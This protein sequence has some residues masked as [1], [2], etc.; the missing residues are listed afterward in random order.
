MKKTL[1]LIM[2]GMIVFAMGTN[3]SLAAK[4]AKSAGGVSQEEMTNMSDTIDRLTKKVYSNSLFAPQ[5][6]SA[7][8]EIKIK[9]DNQ[10]LIAPDA[11]LAPLYYKAAIL[12]KA[13]E[14]KKESIDCFQT[15]LENFPDTALAPRAKQELKTMGIEVV[16]PQKS[17]DG[18]TTG[19]AASIEERITETQNERTNTDDLS[20]ETEAADI[21]SLSNEIESIRPKPIE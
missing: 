18:E 3:D 21:I 12:Y 13:R 10:M 8:I 16:E 5:D 2:L 7:M 9:L 15:I 20:Q 19:Q 4:K 11:S 1:I 6:N 14:Y 17:E